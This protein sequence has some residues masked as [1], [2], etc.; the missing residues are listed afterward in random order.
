MKLGTPKYSKLCLAVRIR[1]IFPWITKDPLSLSLCNY[2]PRDIFLSSVLGFEAIIVVK[3]NSPSTTVFNIKFT[4]ALSI[5]IYRADSVN[6]RAICSSDA[7]DS[8]FVGGRA[9]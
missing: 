6:E 8:F 7:S 3:L 9:A 5:Q 2:A 1:I 4:D